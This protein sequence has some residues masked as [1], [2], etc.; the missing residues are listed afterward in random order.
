[1]CRPFCDMAMVCCSTF[2]S[3]TAAAYLA[4]IFK[5]S[6]ACFRVGCNKKK[7]LYS[8]HSVCNTKHVS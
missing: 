8:S 6:R 1:M 5:K 3:S 2:A 4:V 7:G